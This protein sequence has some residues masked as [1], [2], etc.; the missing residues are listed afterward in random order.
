MRKHLAQLAA[1]NGRSMNAEVVHA[2]AYYFMIQTVP[3]EEMEKVPDLEKGIAD[4]LKEVSRIA[5]AAARIAR[6]D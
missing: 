4:L 3:P 2:L 1:R 5:D 6:K